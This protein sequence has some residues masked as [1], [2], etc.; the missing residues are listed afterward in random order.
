MGARAAWT[1]LGIII[2]LG[3]SVHKTLAEADTLAHHSKFCAP[4][5]IENIDVSD[6]SPNIDSCAACSQ[7]S[8]FPCKKR[9]NRQIENSFSARGQWFDRTMNRR[10]M[11]GDKRGA[12]LPTLWRDRCLRLPPP[13]GCA[14]FPLPGLRQGFHHHVRHPVCQSQAATPMLSRR[15][16]DLLQ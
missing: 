9:G 8:L 10:F 14:A 11:A 2:A 16:C 15:H 13:E 4:Q 7:F 1:A 12:G 5:I 3:C 6:F